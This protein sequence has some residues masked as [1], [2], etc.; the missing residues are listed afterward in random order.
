[1]LVL[2]EYDWLLLWGWKGVDGLLRVLRGRFVLVVVRY[3]VRDD[4]WERGNVLYMGMN[5]VINEDLVSGD[6]DEWN[7]G[8]SSEVMCDGS[9]DVMIS[10]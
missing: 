8:V 4:F 1:M 6:V 5:L 2:N 9:W 7:K 3:C 10:L